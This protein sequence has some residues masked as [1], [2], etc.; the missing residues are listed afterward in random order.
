ML[1]KQRTL[2]W[3]NSENPSNAKKVGKLNLMKWI[4]TLIVQ[5]VV[6]TKFL[7]LLVNKQELENALIVAECIAANAKKQK[8]YKI[9]FVR[10]VNQVIL[11]Q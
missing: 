1:T 6:M 4:F 5:P 7:I 2:Y 10:I 3:E 8:D 9:M 11:N